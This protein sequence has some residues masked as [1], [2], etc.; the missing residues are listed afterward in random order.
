[1]ATENVFQRIDYPGDPEQCQ[2]VGKG[3][4]C[5]YKRV[6]GSQMCPRHGGNKAVESINN[7]AV[8]TYRLAMWQQ[9]VNEF[10]DDGKIKSLRE[11]IGIT[12][13][14]LEAQMN[15]CTNATEL[16]I[17]SHKISDLVMKL[18]KLVTSCHAME[19]KMGMLLDRN[20]ILQL[21]SIVVEIISEFVTDSDSRELASEK[22]L[23][24]LTTTVITKDKA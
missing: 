14:L 3:G 21:G 2:A 20:A 18:D 6:P 10:A 4:Q 13:L 11:E 22:I 16:L 7:E 23:G 9:R 24:A 17:N 15:A 8:R 12:R 1:M 19:M 5:P